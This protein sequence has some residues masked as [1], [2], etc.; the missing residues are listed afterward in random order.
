MLSGTH[1]GGGRSLASCAYLFSLIGSGASS[2]FPCMD[3]IILLI[4][5]S[6]LVDLICAFLISV[7]RRRS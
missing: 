6:N 1:V 3:E 7:P 2:A 5:T 4:L